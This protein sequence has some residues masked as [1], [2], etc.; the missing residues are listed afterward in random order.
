MNSDK[1]FIGDKILSDHTLYWLS[2]YIARLLAQVCFS[3]LKTKTINA[4][5][6]QLGVWTSPSLVVISYYSYEYLNKKQWGRHCHIVIFKYYILLKRKGYRHV[7]KVPKID[8]LKILHLSSRYVICFAD[9][10]R[11]K[12]QNRVIGIADYDY[13]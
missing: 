3:M 10:S 13:E 2:R 8:L 12:H 6:Q 9:W 5:L 7:R 4:N 1:Y 11:L